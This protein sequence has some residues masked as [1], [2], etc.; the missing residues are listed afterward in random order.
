M[1]P[2]RINAPSTQT[3]TTPM[4]TRGVVTTVPEELLSGRGPKTTLAQREMIIVFLENEENYNLITGNGLAS[5]VNQGAPKSQNKL[6]K[7][8]GYR[9][10]AA[11]INRTDAGA[12]WSESMVI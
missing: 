10:L 7:A 8:D 9:R 11:F 12:D 3:T 2:R 4:L 1:P 6:K 5:E